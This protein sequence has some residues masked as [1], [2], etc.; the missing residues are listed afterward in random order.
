MP[1]PQIQPVAEPTNVPTSTA[2][3]VISMATTVMFIEIPPAAVD[4]DGRERL[5]PGRLLDEQSSP[6]RR[7]RRQMMPAVE[8]MNVPAVTTRTAISST[9][10]AMTNP[11]LL[12]A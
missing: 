9:M 7:V 12:D 11:S 6:C 1:A 10:T 5:G 2:S 4:D 8:P 3:T